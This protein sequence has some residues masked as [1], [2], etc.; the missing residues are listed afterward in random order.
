MARPIQAKTF[1]GISR[2]SVQ[3]SGR[4]S[5]TTETS[6]KIVNVTSPG[7]SITKTPASKGAQMCNFNTTNWYVT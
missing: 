2:R 4:W 5:Q 3:K 1:T 6:I 7:V